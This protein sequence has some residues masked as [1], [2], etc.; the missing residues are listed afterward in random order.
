M[1]YEPPPYFILR[2]YRPDI[3]ETNPELEPDK[4]IMGLISTKKISE[5]IWLL[6]VENHPM[7]IL[8]NMKLVKSTHDLWFN[9]SIPTFTVLSDN[10]ITRV[11]MKFNDYIIKHNS[12]IIPMFKMT[13]PC[14]T[15][16]EEFF[17]LNEERYKSFKID[18][19]LPS[20]NK[21]IEELIAKGETCPIS[22]L[23]LT[24]E[25]IRVTTCGHAFSRD[26]ERWI[27]QKGNCPICRAPQTIGGLSKWI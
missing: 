15:L 22:T 2:R 12:G 27:S 26:V 20:A 13:E 9:N 24:R 11:V 21:N 10:K 23:E 18:L 1:N 17:Y 4:D 25:S 7:A 3:V 8:E 5:D 19:G 14:V 16:T 6:T